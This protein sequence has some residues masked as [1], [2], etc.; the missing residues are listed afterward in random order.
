MTI[1]TEPNPE[2]ESAE[3]RQFRE[4]WRE[5][6]RRQRDQHGHQVS[7][8]EPNKHDLPSPETDARSHV[9]PRIILFETGGGPPATR[10]TPDPPHQVLHASHVQIPLSGTIARAVEIYRSAVQHEQESNLDEASRL[11]RQAF[12]LNP[13][14]DRA[15]SKEEERL[16]QL[17]RSTVGI[18]HKKTP[19]ASKGEGKHS[20]ITKDADGKEGKESAHPNKILSDILEN[21]PEVLTFEPVDDRE[22]VPINMIPEE[23]LLHILRNLDATTLE[24][25]ATVSRRARILSLDASIW[26][27][28][29]SL[30][31][32]TSTSVTV[33]NDRYFVYM[34]YKPPQIPE[35]TTVQT[36]VG[37]YDSNYRQ[38][39]IEHPRLR[40]DG[41]YIA[42]CHYV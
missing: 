13:H 30:S 42:V 11:Y 29:Y 21:F 33:S 41:V 38:T 22:S 2:E 18:G 34:A 35:A 12:R 20:H 9:S 8:S 39:Y 24:R 27:Y 23:L 37:S 19:S 28:G 17:S 16:R 25:F 5:E 7:S 4:Q 15:Y 1:N 36:I 26:R 3:L 31:Q 32:I 14:V 6:V 40:L 10:S